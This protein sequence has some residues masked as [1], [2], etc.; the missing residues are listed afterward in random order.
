MPEAE[1]AGERNY[2]AFISYRHK[3][4]DMET[5]KK[6]HRRIEQYTVPADV[7]R[8]GEKKLGLV[9][10]DQDELPIS[11]NLSEN[12]RTALDRSEFLIV[13]CTPDTPGSVWV[14]REIAYFKE[15][16]DEDHVLAI[17]AAGTPETSFPAQL[18]EKRDGSGNVTEIIEPLAANIAAESASKRNRL[19][20]T[21]SLRILASLIGCPYDALYKRE[22]RR[23]T[24]KGCK[25]CGHWRGI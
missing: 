9:F 24:R 3:P 13:V 10:R 22:Q 21:E 8:N 16:H 17:L 7:R 4:L 20:R 12:I 14:Q 18:T 11:N 1:K 25:R 5:A 19:F 23:R 6:L 2:R 15:H